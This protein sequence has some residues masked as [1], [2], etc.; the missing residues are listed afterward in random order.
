MMLSEPT[1]RAPRD[2]GATRDRRSIAPHAGN[3]SAAQCAAC[4]GGDPFSGVFVALFFSQVPVNRQSKSRPRGDANYL[5]SFL[6]MY[7]DKM[8]KGSHLFGNLDNRSVFMDIVK[9]GKRKLAFMVSFPG[10][11]SQVL[12]GVPNQP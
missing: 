7:P 1:A 11:S 8:K 6:K 5:G 12:R 10:K 3:M 2:N 9:L 4:G